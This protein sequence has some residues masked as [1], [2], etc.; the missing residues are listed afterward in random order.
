MDNKPT[1]FLK[2]VAD[3]EKEVK[4]LKVMILDLTKKLE[5]TRKSL[6]GN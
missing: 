5:T 1:P 2:R 6:R 4:D 3:L